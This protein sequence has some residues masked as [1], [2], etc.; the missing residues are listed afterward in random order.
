MHLNLAFSL[1][2]AG[3]AAFGPAKPQLPAPVPGLQLSAS[4]ATLCCTIQQ[5]ELCV[6]FHEIAECVDGEC[7][8]SPP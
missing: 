4:P 3:L 8:C 5:K 6:K 2:V 7:V 1:C